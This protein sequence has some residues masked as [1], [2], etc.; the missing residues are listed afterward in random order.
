MVG[1]GSSHQPS[2]L[3]RCG[4]PATAFDER[5]SGRCSTGPPGL[6]RLARLPGPGHDA[7]RRVEGAARGDGPG[8]DHA[9][10]GDRPL[11]GQLLDRV[12]GAEVVRDRVEAAGVHDPGAG[13]LRC[14]VVGDVHPVHELRLAGEVDVVG[15]GLGARGDQ[16]LAE[17]HVGPD[18]RD[19]DLGARDHRV[20]GGAVR[21]VG[22]DQLE[23]G[24]RGVE[25]REP[26]A[27]RLQLA[28]VAAGQR[29]AQPG[30]ARARRGTPR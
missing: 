12:V 2:T 19:H 25:R 1:S 5:P 4:L 22:L 30:R 27:D 26:V 6:G 20:E 14:R 15:A 29:P 23:V 3:S 8:P 16:R 18:R 24:E 21:A 13:L 7:H 17:L 11:R 9:A 10:H 28:A